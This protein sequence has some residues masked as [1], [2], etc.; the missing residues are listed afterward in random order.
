MNARSARVPLRTP[1][2][3]RARRLVQAFIDACERGDRGGIAAL[4]RTDAILTVDSGGSVP[5]ASHADGPVEIASVIIALLQRHPG[6]HMQPGHINGR[7]GIVLSCEGRVVG[8][9]NAVR[10]GNR[11]EEMWVV[12]NAEKLRHW[13]PM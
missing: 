3:R 6:F 5:G 8:V 9:I 4:M 2:S 13:N 11:V 10:R 7:P 1:W 12:V